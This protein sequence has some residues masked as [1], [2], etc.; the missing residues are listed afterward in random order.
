MYCVGVEPLDSGSSKPPECRLCPRLGLCS[1]QTRVTNYSDQFGFPVQ[2]LQPCIQFAIPLCEL[3]HFRLQFS[4]RHGRNKSHLRLGVT[5]L[6]RASG[7]CDSC[8]E[9]ATLANHIPFGN[10]IRNRKLLSNA[11]FELVRLIALTSSRSRA[12]TRSLSARSSVVSSAGCSPSCTRADRISLFFISSILTWQSLRS[13][14][15]SASFMVPP[16]Q[17]PSVKIT[18]LILDWPR[19]ATSTLRNQSGS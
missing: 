12:N 10:C 17:A 18:R 11:V 15:A 8:Q 4:D 14:S 19:R 7:F 1:L 16:F 13:A 6:P 3:I 2:F 5:I 9:V